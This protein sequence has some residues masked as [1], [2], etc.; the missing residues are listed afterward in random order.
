MTDEANDDWEGADDT[1][2]KEYDTLEIMKVNISGKTFSN[3]ILTL[4]FALTTTEFIKFN[5]F[6]MRAVR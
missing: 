2:S 3:L 6:I 4:D 5:D 1:S